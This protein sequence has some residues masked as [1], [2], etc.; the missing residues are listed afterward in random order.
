M[1]K[2][3]LLA[4][5]LFASAGSVTAQ[6]QS[7]C[8]GS[9]EAVNGDFQTYTG[10]VTQ[11]NNWIN[12]NVDNWTVSHGTPS[13]NGAL[14]MWMWSYSGS[15]EGV[16]MDHNFVANQTYRLTYTINRS[17]DANPSSTFL[18]DL[19][20]GL[21]GSNST[22]LPTPTSQFQVSNQAW[23]NTGVTTTIT[24]VFTVPAGQNF[25]Q[26]WFRP[27]LA[28][29]PNPNQAAVVLDN[30]TIEQQIECPCEVN[31]AFEYQLGNCNFEFFNAS[32]TGAVS[33]NQILGYLWDF[34]D[35]STSTEE[36]P[37]HNFTTPGIY[38]V[39]LTTWA[40]SGSDCCTDVMCQKI[41]VKDKCSPCDFIEAN[42]QASVSITPGT[43]D[44]LFTAL[45]V[46]NDFP[47]ATGYYWDFGD[48]NYGS[49]KEVEH[50]YASAGGYVACLTVF[51]QDPKSGECCSYEVCIEVSTEFEKSEA[52][53]IDLGAINIFPNPSTGVF[54]VKVKKDQVESVEVY[55]LGGQMVNDLEIE[56]GRKATTINASNCSKGMYMVMI[57]TKSGDIYSKKLIIE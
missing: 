53:K 1:K 31:A 35:G 8:F 25:S 55:T 47:G 40:G 24:E 13:A 38:N 19:T 52:T 22:A 16:F 28:G 7:Q 51:Y 23:T 18:V 54:N 15:G 26:I 34:G 14:S 37:T 43:G 12:N 21:T 27:Y 5:L 56:T 2:R 11:G 39:C 45:G 4:M 57:T 41:V 50:T 49:G 6:S 42:A 17:T 30:I 32:S 44:C 33:S 9:N 29:Q 3:I 10:A 48:G 46:D 20:N 36:N